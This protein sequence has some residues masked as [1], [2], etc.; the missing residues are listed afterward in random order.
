MKFTII[1]FGQAGSY[2]A[3]LAYKSLSF[4]IKPALFKESF[5]IRSYLGSEF[6]TS[7]DTT[8]VTPKIIFKDGTD[9]N[10]VRG[11]ALL[12]QNHDIFIESI[13]DIKDEIVIAV[14]AAGGGSGVAMCNDAIKYL[15]K[16]GNQVIVIPFIPDAFEG[17]ACGNSIIFLNELITNYTDRISI[18]PCFIK[19]NKYIEADIMAY[20]FIKALTLPFVLMKDG[21]CRAINTLDKNELYNS[22]KG[23]N[24]LA[25]SINSMN[26]K[27]NL[28]NLR[29]IVYYTMYTEDYAEK[30]NITDR[31]TMVTNTFKQLSTKYGKLV[32]YGE[33][34]INNANLNDSAI[35]EVQ[36]QY[37][38]KNIFIFTNVEY[39]DR[40]NL[41]KQAVIELK[42]KLSATTTDIILDETKEKSK[43]EVYKDLTF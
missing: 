38:G 23:G 32:K 41:S 8:I 1:G 2:A 20:E 4:Y 39:K 9:R 25:I 37:Q 17:N 3:C 28:D 6:D 35:Q 31:N 5:S 24:F 21:K 11:M 36:E 12:R 43:K 14:V 16:Q 29:I 7:V 26:P 19:N 33:V 40:I 10:I 18:V 27:C 42:N 30:I 34:S 15:L 13:S 22:L